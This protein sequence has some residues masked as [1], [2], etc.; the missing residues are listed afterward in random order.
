MLIK[1]PGFKIDFERKVLKPES[2]L[3]IL[4]TEVLDLENEM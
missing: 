3:N 1:N 2:G 4:K